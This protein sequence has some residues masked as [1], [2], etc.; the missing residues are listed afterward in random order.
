MIWAPGSSGGKD[1]TKE[2]WKKKILL[3]ATQGHSQSYE[4]LKGTHAKLLTWP[5]KTL[6]DRE[7]PHKIIN[8]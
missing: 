5:V 2:V 3:N 6:F 1:T 7:D 8:N 4:G